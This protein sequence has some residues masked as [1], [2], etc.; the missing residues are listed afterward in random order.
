MGGW[1]REGGEGREEGWGESETFKVYSDPVG[2][3]EL[4]FKSSFLF[5]FSFVFFSFI[6]LFHFLFVFHFLF[7]NFPQ[8]GQQ[9]I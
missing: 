8:N 5:F 6:F 1:E 9:P 2:R 3:A 7:W 4:G